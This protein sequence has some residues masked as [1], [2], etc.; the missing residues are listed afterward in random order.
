MWWSRAQNT[1]YIK[2]QN[3]TENKMVF[4]KCSWLPTDIYVHICC[5]VVLLGWCWDMGNEIN[6]L[7]CLTPKCGHRVPHWASFLHYNKK[8]RW[9]KIVTSKNTR[10]SGQYWH[11][12]LT[13][14]LHLFLIQLSFYKKNSPLHISPVTDYRCYSLILQCLK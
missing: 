5:D 7:Y 12:S 14:K 9:K 11:H 2:W 1:K 6:K 4:V 13:V 10:I 8:E 3:I